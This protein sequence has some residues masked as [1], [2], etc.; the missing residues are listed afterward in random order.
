MS[1]EA[2]ALVERYSNPEPF[3]GRRS[4][5]PEVIKWDYPEP[6]EHLWTMASGAKIKLKDMTVE[7]R[8]AA[9]A[10]IVRRYGPAGADTPTGRALVAVG[11]LS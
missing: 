11:V 2:D 5:R 10:L 7:H 3:R 8:T 9:L 6:G 4:R 1:D